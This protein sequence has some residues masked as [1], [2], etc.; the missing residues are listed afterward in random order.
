MTHKRSI[1]VKRKSL[2]L[3]IFQ[4]VTSLKDILGEWDH[5]NS[6]NAWMRA[7]KEKKLA[8]I[9]NLKSIELN[10]DIRWLLANDMT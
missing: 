2:D 1:V 4:I 6:K 8:Q 5:R 9:V 3:N 7:S 10:H